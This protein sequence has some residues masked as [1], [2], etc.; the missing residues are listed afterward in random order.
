MRRVRSGQTSDGKWTH[1]AAKL[2]GAVIEA[3]RRAAVASDDGHLS[4]R[5]NRPSSPGFYFYCHVKTPPGWRRKKK[6]PCFPLLRLNSK[7]GCDSEGIHSVP[8]LWDCCWD[9]YVRWKQLKVTKL[10]FIPRCVLSVRT[11]QGRFSSCKNVDSVLPCFRPLFRRWRLNLKGRP[12]GV[13]RA[14]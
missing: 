2:R 4:Y 12:G 6:A 8:P 1:R 5:G 14:H 11:C 13:M 3:D 7:S 10:G 9:Y